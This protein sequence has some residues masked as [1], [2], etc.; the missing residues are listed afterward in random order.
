MPDKSVKPSLVLA[1]A[2]CLAAL[3]PGSVLR[4]Q[5]QPGTVTVTGT[6]P[7]YCPSSNGFYPGTGYTVTCYEG[8]G[9]L[10]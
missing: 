6:G 10:Q 7:Q 1:V 3:L 4:A 2:I 5:L 9:R 8:P